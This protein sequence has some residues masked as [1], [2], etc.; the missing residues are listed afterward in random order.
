MEDVTDPEVQQ[1][2]AVR[3]FERLIGIME[4]HDS[5]AAEEFWTRHMDA[6]YG[7]MARENSGTLISGIFR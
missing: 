3:A 7:A 4:K 2:R 1:S 6:V 5:Q